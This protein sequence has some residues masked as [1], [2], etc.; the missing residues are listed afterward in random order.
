[1]NFVWYVAERDATHASGCGIPS[2]GAPMHP[3]RKSTSFGGLWRHLVLF[4]MSASG[5]SIKT[6][7]AHMKF[8]TPPWERFLLVPNEHPGAPK[9]PER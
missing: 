1:M 5:V 8:H 7:L 2:P 4:G 6:I 3:E 9:A